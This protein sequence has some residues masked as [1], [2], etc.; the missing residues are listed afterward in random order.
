MEYTVRMNDNAYT[1]RMAA[2]ASMVLLKNVSETLPLLK[3]SGEALPV[4]VFGIGQIFTPLHGK[5]MQPW[6]ESCI[7]DGLCQA[8]TVRPDSL[9]AHKYRSW[10]LEHPQMEELPLTKLDM[11]TLAAEN[12]AAVVVLARQPGQKELQLR[13]KEKELLRTVTAA[14]TRTVLVLAAPGY[15]ELTEEAMACG[16]MVFMGIAGQEGGA[17]LADLLTAKVMPSGRLA[18]TWAM[19]EKDYDEACERA[20]RFVGYRYF[21]SFGKEVRWPFGY[22]QTYGKCEFGAVSAGLDGCDVTVS[23][24]VLNTGSK[25]PASEVVQVYVSYPDTEQDMPVWILDCFKRTKVLMPGESETVQ[26]RFPIAELSRFREE[27][28]AFVLQD[29]FYD[30]RVGTSSRDTVV[31][32]SIRVTRSAVVQATTPMRFGTEESRRRNGSEYTYPGQAEELEA[33]RKVAIRFSDRNLPRRSRKKGS[34]FAGCRS[35]GTFHTLADVRNGSCNLFQ[36]IACMD[37][38]ELESLADRYSR[39]PKNGFFTIPG[40]EQYGIPAL[41]AAYGCEGLYLE[42]VDRD[43]E[44]EV[45]FRRNLTA[46]PAAS[47][48]PTADWATYRRSCGGRPPRDMAEFAFLDS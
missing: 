31:A 10:A 38:T 17:A 42:K 48:R 47:L 3:Q 39:I 5:N 37:D 9:L 46:F 27:A 45:I 26:L 22:G 15:L 25:W 8:G 40:M 1:A 12:Q 13:D 16:A 34:V 41:Q 30:I 28:S 33:A 21:D 32:G 2:C 36:L 23:A 20:D 43:E 18:F 14:F 4:A 7:L 29:G 19:R 24:E 44:D 35:D 11:Q 6:R